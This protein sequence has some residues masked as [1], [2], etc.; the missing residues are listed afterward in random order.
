MNHQKVV[1]EEKWGAVEMTPANID[2]Y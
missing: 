2:L 1:S